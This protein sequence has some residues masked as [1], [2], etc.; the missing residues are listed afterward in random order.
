MTRFIDFLN[1]DQHLYSPKTYLHKYKVNY[2]IFYFFLQLSI[3]PFVH[4]IYIIIILLIYLI[5][6][7]QIKIP[8]KIKNKWLILFN[9]ITFVYIIHMYFITQ[10]KMKNIGF[11][12]K[13]IIIIR[14][15]DFFNDFIPYQI[16][17]LEKITQLSI[18]ISLG[19]FRLTS[20]S[21]IYIITIHIILLTTSY[22][23]IIYFLIKKIKNNTNLF[24]YNKT[25]FII[26]IASQFI[27]T[28]LLEIIKLHKSYNIRNTII[29][30]K[31]ILNK[32]NTNNN[33]YF[34]INY[35]SRLFY[36]IHYITYALYSRS[37][38]IN[39]LF[40]YINN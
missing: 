20:I 1:Y 39:N 40:F 38:Y 28:I 24:F 17:I 3:I 18:C 33:Y 29:I 32:Q 22:E 12:N 26:I 34:F 16:N 4:Q 30:N 6:L 14:P 5:I 19:F 27:K 15:F 7:S 8:K 35:L 36:Y 11:Y 25:N 2:K 13:S 10:T 37:I 9:M 21:I 23:T 31:R